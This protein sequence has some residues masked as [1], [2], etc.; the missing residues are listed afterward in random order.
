MTLLEQKMFSA[1]QNSIKQEMD[2]YTRYVPF[3][4][5]KNLIEEISNYQFE[6][7]SWKLMEALEKAKKDQEV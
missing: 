6:Q 4:E 5:P 7:L 2:L 1:I 3:P